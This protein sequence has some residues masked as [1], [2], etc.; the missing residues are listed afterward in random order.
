MAAANRA[1]NVYLNDHLAGAMLGS[2]LAEQIRQRHEG[3]PLGDLMAT[4]AP[5]IE[6][7]RQILVDMME[8]MEISKNP[9]KQASGWLAEKASRVKFSGAGSGEPDHGAF[10]ALESLTLG[11]EGKASM[12]KVLKEVQS[13]YQ[14][15]ASINLDQLIERAGA[16]H[17]ALERERMAAGARA[18]ADGADRS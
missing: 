5:E 15:L 6:D 11:V 4:I 14:A 8:R 3:T 1:M 7:D 17:A 18:L 9:L 10:M 12:W 13:D 2:D 16:Q